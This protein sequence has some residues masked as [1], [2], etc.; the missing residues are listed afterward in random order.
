[1]RQGSP[2][3]LFYSYSHKDE[4]FREELE[5][6]LA[7]LRRRGVI[8]EWHD[9]KIDPGDEW[10]KEI[11]T[12]L[13]EANV[14]LLLVT[15]DFMAS[16]FCYETELER[17]LERHGRGE[18]VVVP[19]VV[20]PVDFEDSP[21]AHLQALPTDAKPVTLWDDRDE[22]WL[23]VA[24]G[25]RSVC[26]T[27]ADLSG[28]ETTSESAEGAPEDIVD[29][30]DFGIVDF[31]AVLEERFETIM[32]TQKHV[33]GRTEEVTESLLTEGAK[34]TALRDYAGH[35]KAR[36][37]RDVARSMG[38]T[39]SSFAKEMTTLASDLD[40]SWS[41]IDRL[42]PRML[43]SSVGEQPLPQESIDQLIELRNTIG[44]L[45]P[46]TRNAKESV[47]QTAGVVAELGQHSAHL[48]L[49]TRPAAKSLER[50]RDAYWRIESSLGQMERFLGDLI[51][52]S[53]HPQA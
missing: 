43:S 1:M 8:S 50:F 44:S 7:I 30:A 40:V 15:P 18:V 52:E 47:A 28:L 53:G 49:G 35:D 42:F 10:R 45:V 48:R 22:A 27:A 41:D 23:S 24:R 9:R 13:D 2:V 11:S 16:D 31:N 20:R 5:T 37:A 21:F 4:A 25:I 19:I 3:H 36:R 32:E 34:L 14:I 12:Q 29:E 6:H 38:R 51:D 33:T 26:A 46:V 39:L 17:A